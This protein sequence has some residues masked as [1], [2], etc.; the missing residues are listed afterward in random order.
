MFA[1]INGNPYMSFI[2]RPRRGQN[3]GIRVEGD[4]QSQIKNKQTD[5]QTRWGEREA[6]TWLKGE[7]TNKQVMISLQGMAEF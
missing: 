7:K 1:L 3:S 4:T 2:T 5:K 6:N